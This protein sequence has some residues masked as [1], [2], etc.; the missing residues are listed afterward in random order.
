MTTSLVI[1]EPGS[2]Q[3]ISVKPPPA[4]RYKLGVV[5]ISANDIATELKA[6]R[7]DLMLHPVILKPS[8]CSLCIFCVLHYLY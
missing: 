3:L 2:S 5:S 4:K 1:G 6:L 7:E 8:K